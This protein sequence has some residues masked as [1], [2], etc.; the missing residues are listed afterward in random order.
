MANEISTV[1]LN[2]SVRAT[3]TPA[4][5]RMVSIQYINTQG[6]CLVDDQGNA[7]PIAG[8]RQITSSDSSID[9]TNAFGPT[10]DLGTH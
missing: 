7:T 9:I 10:T 4:P 1:A 5:Q 6:L 8:I 3:P 2:L